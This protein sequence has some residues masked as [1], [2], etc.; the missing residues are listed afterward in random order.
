MSELN[1]SIRHIERPDRIKRLKISDRG[2][3]VPWFVAWLDGVADFR[4]IAPGKMT[5]AHNR[6]RCWICGGPL[7]RYLAFT[8][9]PMCA[10]NRTSSEPPSHTDCAE[11][12]AKACPFLSK[13]NMRRN[14]KELP[15]H[16]EIAGTAIM[17]NP[18]VALVYVT[19]SYRP[20]SDGRGGVLFELGEPVSASF[21][22]ESRP[23]TRDEIMQ[24][25]D[26]GLP[27]LREVA[28]K[29]NALD[30]LQ[31]YIDRALKLL[32]AA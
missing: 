20:I 22:C 5:Q 25:I 12:A 24:S 30:E 27:Y 18:G 4:V 3:P 29:E 6:H 7:G 13:P 23:A 16:G 10:I 17:H 31:C 26:K 9:G 15:E 19:H 32:P 2:F 1:Q 14:E 28:A 21:F 11:Y 8:I